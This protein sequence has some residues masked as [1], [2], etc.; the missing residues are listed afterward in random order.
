MFLKDFLMIVKIPWILQSGI[1]MSLVS[2][3]NTIYPQFHFKFHSVFTKESHKAFCKDFHKGFY[4]G[5][6]AEF[7]WI[8]G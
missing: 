8:F 5:L 6:Q 3:L 1:F 2:P 4:F 7:H